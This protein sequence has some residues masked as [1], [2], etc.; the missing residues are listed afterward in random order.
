MKVQDHD[1]D[2]DDGSR[3]DDDV[4]HICMGST[5]RQLDGVGCTQ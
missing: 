3:D 1:D 4:D 5:E 2:D